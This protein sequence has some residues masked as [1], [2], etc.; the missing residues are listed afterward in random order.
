[1]VVDS[2]STCSIKSAADLG[3]FEKEYMAQS[4]NEQLNQLRKETI[5]DGVGSTTT[6]VLIE[7]SDR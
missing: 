2:A 3:A 6:S 4:A 5:S 1:M 7:I